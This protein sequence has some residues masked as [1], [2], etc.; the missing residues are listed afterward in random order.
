ML[1]IC[2]SIQP[3]TRLVG[4]LNITPDSFSDG[5][6]F[7]SAAAA[8]NH[9]EQLFADGA[10]LIDVGAESTRPGATVLDWEQEWQRL[11]PI[12]PELLKRHPDKISLDTYHPETAAAALKLGNVIINDISGMQNP[13]MRQVVARHHAR[14]IVSFLPAKDAQTAHTQ[15]LVNDV[16]LVIDGLQQTRAE[17]VA[18]GLPF[19]HIILDPGIGF[20][21]TPELNWKLLGF[22]K[23]MPESPILIGYSRK[24]FFGRKPYGNRT[25]L[26]CSRYCRICW[27]CIFA[28]P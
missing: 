5:G 13:H 6:L 18:L 4:I 12:L 14:C 22:A 20:G 25:K 17:L 2:A 1:I 23:Y 16:N 28:R 15:T 9:A 26:G 3:M 19:E 7:N 11:E 24:R 27:H 8:L 21:K 10:D